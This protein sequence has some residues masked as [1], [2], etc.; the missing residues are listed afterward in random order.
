MVGGSLAML[1]VFFFLR[2]FRSTLVVATSIPVSV[3]STFTFLYAMGYSLNT[4]TLVGLALATG[5]IVDHAV[6][7]M[8]N[9]YRRME[10]GLDPVRAS[11]EGTQ[12]ITSAVLSSTITLMV[13][14]LPL[15]MIPGQVGQMFRP[16]ALVIVVSLAFSL[17]DAL[18][19]VPMLCSQFIRIQHQSEGF[20]ARQFTRWEGWH[21]S[22][23]RIY[24]QILKN[25]LR[26]PGRVF[27]GG[28]LVTLLSLTFL[29][30]L[31]YSFLP[32]T[33]A[34]NLYVRLNMPRGTSLQET[35]KA[36]ARV[37][38]ILGKLPDVESYLATVGSDGTRDQG[39]IIVR[40]K[41]SRR[42]SSQQ[43][44]MA[45]KGQLMRIA[46]ARAFAFP[47]NLVGIVMGGSQGTSMD[48]DLFGPDL[49]T[50]ASLSDQR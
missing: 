10:S 9:I 31:G 47:L 4:M 46:G 17:L 49:D 44:S 13:V 36:V 37:E 22:L 33:D 18:T 19:G 25:A 11:I 28:L 35:D 30:L 29:P 20:W 45:L 7:V 6:V 23:D 12:E 24:Q 27:T 16:F 40:L 42:A 43:I 48:L 5:L 39:Q 32:R 21:L 50:L 14:F 34:D 38:E 2:N 26:Y 41:D 15:V 3:V 8:E 1:I